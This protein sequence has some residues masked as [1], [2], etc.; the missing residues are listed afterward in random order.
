MSRVVRNYCPEN[1]GLKI[2]FQWKFAKNNTQI[3]WKYSSQINME[4]VN[5]SG[6]QLHFIKKLVSEKDRYFIPD[7]MLQK[8]NNKNCYCKNNSG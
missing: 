2:S 3:L 7:S 1:N 6:F 5:I 4:K 8:M